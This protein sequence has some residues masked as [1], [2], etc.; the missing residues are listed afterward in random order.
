MALSNITQLREAIAKYLNRDDLSGEIDTFIALAEARH[1][2]DIR[3]QEMLNRDAL[4]VNNRYVALPTGLLEAKTVRLLTSPRTVLEQVSPHEMDRI[5]QS[6]TGKPKAFT[7]HKTFEFDRGPDQSYSGEIVYY[8][9][10]TALDDTNTSNN[11]LAR[12]PGLY[13]YGALVEAEPFL[14]NDPRIQVWSQMYAAAR[15]MV[16]ANHR[17]QLRAGPQASRVFGA[18]P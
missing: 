12:H 10:E 17:K 7:I 11:I 8:K 18:T 2:N 6:G 3:I 15:D 1:K 9:E 16:N 14:R 5:S 4:T 13:L